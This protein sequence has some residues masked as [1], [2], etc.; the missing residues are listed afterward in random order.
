VFEYTAGVLRGIRR[1]GHPERN[2]H[3]ALSISAKGK[4]IDYWLQHYA[5]D[6]DYIDIISHWYVH[7]WCFDY[8]IDII[9]DWG[10]ILLIYYATATPHRLHILLHM[11]HIT[12]FDYW[13]H[14]AFAI[15]DYFVDYIDFDID[16]DID[17]DIA[18][19]YGYWSLPLLILIITGYYWLRHYILTLL[20]HYILLILIATLFA[21]MPT[22]RWYWYWLFSLMPPLMPFH[23]L[24]I[25]IDIIISPLPLI[26]T[27]R[28]YIIA[29]ID[30]IMI[31]DTHTLILITPYW[32][33]ITPLPLILLLLRYAATLRH[34][35]Y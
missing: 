26:F 31:I 2:V 28:W 6:Y 29:I 14:I 9:I 32:L 19:R 25:D 22:L 7:Y 21:I 17:I 8:A 4:T 35:C 24:I 5:I 20:R 1:H 3:K 23:Y 27:L 30:D 13:L 16:I 11:S 15:I 18:M 33:L 12:H 34:W 10:H